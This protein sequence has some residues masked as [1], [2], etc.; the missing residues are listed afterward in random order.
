M[1]NVLLI[2]WDP[3]GLDE[4]AERLE[5]AGFDVGVCTKDGSAAFRAVGVSAPHAVV[6]DLSRQPS[7][8]KRLALALRD[9][10]TTRHIPVVFVDGA[11]DAVASVREAIPEATVATW[12]GIG[13]AVKKAI[14]EAARRAEAV[15]LAR[16]SGR[17]A[18]PPPKPSGRTLVPAPRSSSRGATPSP[19]PSTP[20]TNAP[21]RAR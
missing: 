11:A 6:I 20:G 10:R 9:K 17:G 12:R 15:P 8:G 3:N 4:R 21:R 1:P 13:G 16:A 18:V 2:H 7:H 19:R 5:R 14:A